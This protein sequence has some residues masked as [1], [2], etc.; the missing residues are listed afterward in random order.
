MATILVGLEVPL[1]QDGRDEQPLNIVITSTSK[2]AKVVKVVFVMAVIKCGV[3]S[4][5]CGVIFIQLQTPHS[6]LMIF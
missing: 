1:L 6:K 2:A 5:E 3:W 4:V